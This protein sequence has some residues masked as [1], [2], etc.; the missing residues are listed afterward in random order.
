[1]RLRP[2][3]CVFGSLELLRL[4]FVTRFR[5]KGPY[6]HWRMETAFGRGKPPRAEMLRAALRYGAW[7]RRMR[8]GV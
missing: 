5:F 1:M 4:A 3:E 2:S 7:A 6:W 8:K